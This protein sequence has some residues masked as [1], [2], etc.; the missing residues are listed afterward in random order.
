MVLAMMHCAGLH[1]LSCLAWLYLSRPPPLQPKPKPKPT[2]STSTFTSSLI[3]EAN[4][5]YADHK[6]NPRT[7]AAPTNL[8]LV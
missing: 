7:T 1:R 5:N 4:Q 3:Y 2:H 8:I 6:P